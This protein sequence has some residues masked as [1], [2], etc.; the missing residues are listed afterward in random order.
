MDEIWVEA[1]TTSLKL[2]GSFCDPVRADTGNGEIDGKA[3]KV[4]AAFC[5]LPSDP[6]EMFVVCGRP[7]PGN[8]IDFLPVG[9][10][11]SD[12]TK[13]VYY[14]DADG[15]HLVCI[16]AAQEVMDTIY[17]LWE[18]V[19]ANPVTSVDSLPGV[20]IVQLQGFLCSAFGDCGSK[21]IP[22]AT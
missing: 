19:R 14:L 3:V 10:Q 13:K 9:K 4:E 21:N 18:V 2:C 15:L 5:Y 11:V 16:M 8:N 20:D 17:L 7:I 22:Q 6:S 12:V 1:D